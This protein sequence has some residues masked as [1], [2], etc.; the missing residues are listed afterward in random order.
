LSIDNELQQIKEAKKG[1][2]VRGALHDGLRT[3]YNVA[4]RSESNSERIKQRYDDILLNWDSDPNKDPELINARGG[5]NQLVD[6]LENMDSEIESKA[7]SADVTAD[8]EQ[9]EVRLSEDLAEAVGQIEEELNKE[10]TDTQL[11]RVKVDN[12]SI[13]AVGGVLSTRNNLRPLVAPEGFNWQD[14]PLK[15]KIFV[16]A[17][18]NYII[19]DFD[20]SKHKPVG[21][22]YYV[23]QA[24]GDDSNDGLSLQTAFRTRAHAMTRPDARV[25]K[26]AEGIYPRPSEQIFIQQD[27]AL[28]ALGGHDVYFVNSQGPTFSPYNNI[29]R[30]NT[31]GGYMFL[32]PSQKDDEGDFVKYQELT[33]IAAVE[34]TPGSFA[35]VGAYTYIHTFSGNAPQINVNFVRLAGLDNV[36]VNGGYT[37]YSK[38]I[39]YIGGNT[40]FRTDNP[41]ARPLRIFME[42][43]TFQHSQTDEYDGTLIRGSELT[44]LKNCVAKDNKKDGFNYATSGDNVTLAIEIDCVGK[45]NGTAGSDSDQGSTMHQGGKIIRINGTYHSNYGANIGDTHAETQSW[46]IGCIAYNPL[47]DSLNRRANFHNIGGQ[48]MWLEGC[49]SYD[50]NGGSHT[51]GAVTVKDSNFI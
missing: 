28:E 12:Q 3:A 4:K 13:K 41:S 26:F 16:D 5:E 23:D 9:A 46:N 18:G 48:D 34:S 1:K 44:I 31:T 21:K 10:A 42:D 14:H 38:G 19:R 35:F 40:I 8:L 20:L 47:A 36:R 45:R 32:D 17:Q 11:G 6:R 2:E 22:T 37:F 29:Y 24:N 51:A 7:S 43:C 33:S 49:L 30:A 25:L 39:K 27:L 15:N 50:T